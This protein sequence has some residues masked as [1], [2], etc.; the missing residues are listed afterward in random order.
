MTTAAVVR[1]SIWVVCNTP[2]AAS[3]DTPIADP[4]APYFDWPL[5][6]PPSY[7]E[8]F[9][10]A[11]RNG[12]IGWRQRVPGVTLG[13]LTEAGGAVFVPDSNG[14]FRALE[15]RSGR[16]LWKTR[17][18]APIGGGATVA[19]GMVLIGY[20]VQFGGAERSVRP[21]AGSRGGIVAYAPRR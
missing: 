19:G 11:A 5:H 1:G 20:G 4:T 9:R 12:R 18:G 6:E 14:T 21:P 8:I 10:L 15:A 13:A 17:P 7:S 3:L 16:V 2:S